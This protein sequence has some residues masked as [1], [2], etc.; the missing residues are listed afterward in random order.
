MTEQESVDLV[1]VI[2]TMY[3]D[4]DAPAE[5]LASYASILSRYDK[6]DADQG[7]ARLMHAYQSRKLPTIARIEEQILSTSPALQ[8]WRVLADAVAA[9]ANTP[10]EWPSQLAREAV[11]RLGGWTTL[12]QWDGS[13]DTLREAYTRAYSAA[14]DKAEQTASAVPQLAS[15]EQKTLNLSG[16]ETCAYCLDDGWVELA[17]TVKQAGVTYQRGVTACRWCELGE[18]VYRSATSGH[19]TKT[20]GWWPAYRLANDYTAADLAAP[21]AVLDAEAVPLATYAASDVG[22]ADTALRD[23]RVQALLGLIR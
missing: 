17:G 14:A 21:P 8:S 13:M 15:G 1:A 3:P 2:R 22:Q 6:Q 5:L 12:L 16:S 23:E 4:G 18:A 20:G 7:V 10:P 9:R 19:E 11:Q